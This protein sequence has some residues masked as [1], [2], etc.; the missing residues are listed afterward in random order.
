[1]ITQDQL[2]SFFEDTDEEIIEKFVDP[3][4]A[5][6]TRFEINNSNRIAMLWAQARC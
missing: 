5:A 1:M 2:Q 3:L 4:N 6:M